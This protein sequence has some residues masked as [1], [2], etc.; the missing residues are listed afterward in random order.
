MSNENQYGILYADDMNFRLPA[1]ELLSNWLCPCGTRVCVGVFTGHS[2][3]GSS[4]SIAQTHTER[5]GEKESD[6]TN[7][8][9]MSKIVRKLF[10]SPIIGNEYANMSRSIN[11]NV[12][13]VLTEQMQNTWPIWWTQPKVKRCVVCRRILVIYR[14]QAAHSLR[15]TGPLPGHFSNWHPFPLCWVAGELLAVVAVDAVDATVVS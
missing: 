1:N 14:R 6:N 13:T 3:I 8:E 2:I 4:D 10:A 12:N 15:R 9:V 7:L 5:E 11:I